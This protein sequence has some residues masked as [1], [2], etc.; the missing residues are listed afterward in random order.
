M[1]RCVHLTVHITKLQL[2]TSFPCIHGRWKSWCL[3]CL[4]PVR[5]QHIA[6]HGKKPET[7]NICWVCCW[8]WYQN[9][10]GA[11]L[12]PGMPFLD[13]DTCAEGGYLFPPGFSSLYDAIHGWMTGRMDGKLHKKRPQHPL[14]YVTLDG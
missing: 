14:L 9:R 7:A 3:N 6:D 5:E 12:G 4:W 8:Y 1:H 10:G 2:Q 11:P 13:S